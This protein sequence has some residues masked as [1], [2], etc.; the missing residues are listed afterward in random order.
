MATFAEFFA[1]I[2]LVRGA[3]EPLG[4]RC[5]FANDVSPGK[6]EMYRARFGLRHFAVDD[7]NNLTVDQLPADVDLFTASFPCVDLSLAGN[8][9][10]LAGVHS[11]TIWPFLKLLADRCLFGNAPT[12][13]L[14]E[15]VTG[16]LS[17]HGEGIWPKSASSWQ[18]WGTR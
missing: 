10:G 6:A 1:G 8:R 5:V 11:G 16:F 9:Y 18:S 13:V 12:A 4:W 3:M 17:S 7:V 14:L 2:G 15:N